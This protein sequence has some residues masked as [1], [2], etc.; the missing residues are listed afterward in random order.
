M[1]EPSGIGT[2]HLRAARPTD[3]LDAVVVTGEA[4]GAWA[5]ERRD[6]GWVQVPDPPRAVTSTVTLPPDTAWKVVTKRWGRKAVLARFPDI[7]IEG[8]QAL[9]EHVLD[10]VSV[11]A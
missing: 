11:M 8:D 2:A 4:G 6:G 7:R 10:M 1:D 5:V 3:D 9:G